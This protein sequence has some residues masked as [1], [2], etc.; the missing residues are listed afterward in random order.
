MVIETFLVFVRFHDSVISEGI[1]KPHCERNIKISMMQL[2][3]TQIRLRMI[4]FSA[5]LRAVEVL[6]LVEISL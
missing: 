5:R 2:L 1:F 3:S 6:R 4:F